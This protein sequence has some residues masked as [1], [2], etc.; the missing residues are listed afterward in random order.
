MND[1]MAVLIHLFDSPSF[2]LTH[3][4]P[5]KGFLV[6]VLVNLSLLL[7][8]V[9]SDRLARERRG[10]R[11]FSDHGWARPTVKWSAWVTAESRGS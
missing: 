6:L 4:F 7:Y 11:E 2:L 9:V 5:M 10:L 8:C 1:V 3:R